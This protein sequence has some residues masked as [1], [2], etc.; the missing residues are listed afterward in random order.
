MVLLSKLYLFQN[1]L[2]DE[3]FICFAPS[4][5]LL[6]IYGSIKPMTLFYKS[7]ILLAMYFIL[8]TV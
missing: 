1:A 4:I 3:Q 8:T 6:H 7:R 2:T 5:F